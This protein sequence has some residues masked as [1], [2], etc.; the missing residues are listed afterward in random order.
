L[1]ADD[2]IV[3]LIMKCE[4]FI[5]HQPTFIKFRQKFIASRNWQAWHNTYYDTAVNMHSLQELVS[6]KSPKFHKTFAPLKILT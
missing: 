5:N 1:E 3:T 2:N 4:W 6:H